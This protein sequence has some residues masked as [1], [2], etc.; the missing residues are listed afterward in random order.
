MEWA[1]QTSAQATPVA[2]SPDGETLITAEEGDLGQVLDLWDVD[3]GDLLGQLPVCLASDQGGCGPDEVGEL[4]V[5]PQGTIIVSGLY[6]SGVLLVD[7]ALV[8]TKFS[9][10]RARLC[11]LAGRSLTRAEWR[12]YLPNWSYQTLC[13]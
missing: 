13:A 4:A 3:T 6:D 2:F 10:L 9:V 7:P 1:L 12:T 5:T 11:P 8:S